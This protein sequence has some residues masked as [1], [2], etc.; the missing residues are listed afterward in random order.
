MPEKGEV[1]SQRGCGKATI[2]YLAYTKLLIHFFSQI[3]TV[4]T[5]ESNVAI[6]N[7]TYNLWQDSLTDIKRISG[8]TWSLS[9]EPLPSAIYKKV[10][11][12]NT[13][14]LGNR[15]TPLVVVLLTASF[16]YATDKPAV[17][18][19]SRKLMSSIEEEARGQG[20]YDPWVYLGYAAPWQD[21]IASYGVESLERLREVQGRVDPHGMFRRQVPGG[22]KI[23]HKTGM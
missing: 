8:I 21:P 1:R 18:A 6:L 23:R 3:S 20:V 12:K 22:F 15:T 9:L 7:A 5:Y 14:G 17:E 19:A 16:K 10:A 4:L 13:L 11:E 2:P